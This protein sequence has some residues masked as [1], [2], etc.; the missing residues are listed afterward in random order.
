MRYNPSTDQARYIDAIAEECKAA[1][2]ADDSR[3]IWGLTLAAEDAF[4]ADSCRVWALCRDGAI[5]CGDRNRAARLEGF[6]AAD[7][8][9]AMHHRPH[10]PLY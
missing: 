4:A 9:K 7:M 6:L 3:P 5:N 8:H 1:I 10:Q 2:T